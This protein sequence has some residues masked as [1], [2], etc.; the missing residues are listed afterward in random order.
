MNGFV[1]LSPPAHMSGSLFTA[2]SLNLKCGLCNEPHSNL[3]EQQEP[4]SFIQRSKLKNSFTFA[5]KDKCVKSLIHFL[6]V[7]SCL[8][9]AYCPPCIEKS[10]VRDLITA[11]PPSVWGSEFWIRYP[12]KKVPWAS[13]IYC[14]LIVQ[15][16][17]V[18]NVSIWE[19]TTSF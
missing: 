4:Q 17:Q 14:A 10:Q 6:K 7:P 3:Q 1:M 16:L 13:E 12:H 18:R 15:L 8:H 5:K 11:R 19:R 2:H 9:N